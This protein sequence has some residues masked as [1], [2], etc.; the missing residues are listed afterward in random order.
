[1]IRKQNNLIMS[2][3]ALQ[4]SRHRITRPHHL[5]T[6]KRRL[7]PL[8]RLLLHQT[9]PPL[10]QKVPLRILQRNASR[11]R[12]ATK[13]LVPGASSENSRTFSINPNSPLSNRP[14]TFAQIPAPLELHPVAK[15][16]SFRKGRGRK[17]PPRPPKRPHPLRPHRRP[18]R[19]CARQRGRHDE[20]HQCCGTLHQSRRASR[21]VNRQCGER[22]CDADS[23]E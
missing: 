7:H 2:R 1:M 10:G 23:G 12:P 11:P 22:E 20:R 17:P 6:C 3:N 16:A 13:A 14:F 18:P 9:R 8:R 15:H 5:Q 19:V 4:V 21:R